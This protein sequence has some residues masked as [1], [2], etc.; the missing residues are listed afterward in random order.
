MAVDTPERERSTS[1]EHLAIR[2]GTLHYRAKVAL[3]HPAT[4]IGLVLIALFGYLIVAPVISLLL[5]GLQVGFGDEAKT[6]AAAGDFTGYYLERVFDSPVSSIIFYGP[7]LNTLLVAGSSILLALAIGVPVA[8]LLSRTDLPGRRWFSGALIIPYMLPAWTFA[9]AWTTI[10]KNRSSAGQL[11]WME[12]IGWEPPNWLAY[13]PLPIVVIFALHFIPF[14]ILLVTNAMKNLPGELDEAAKM[15]GATPWTRWRRI[16]LPLMRPAVL[17][18][19]TLMFAK[20]IGEF[21][22]AY[23]L[24]MPAGFQVL[25]TTLYQSISTQQAGVAGVIAAVM[26]G[27]GAIS[28]M[29]D[30]RFLREARRFTTLSGRSGASRSASL[31]RWRGVAWGA[32]A[33]LFF[34][35]VIVP[36]GTLLLSTLMRIPGNF[37]ASN[38]TLDYWIGH[39][40]PTAGFTSGVLVSAQTWAAAWNTIWMVGLA[41]GITG[42]LGLLVGYVVV[43]CPVPRLG[44]TLRV[45]TFMPYLVPGIAFAVAYLSLFAV[46]R[47]P[48]PALYGTAAILILIMV[49]D[50]MPFASR[51]GVS[52]MMQLGNEPEE[53][54]QSL[55]ARWSRRMRTI[56]IPL[57]RSALASATLLPFISGVQ[58]LSL[59][60]ILATP[61][62]QLLT[63][64]SM[65]LIDFGYTHAANAV[66]VVICA[67]ALL[68]SWA[69]QRLFRSNLAAGLGG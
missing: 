26:V 1:R 52:A 53:A 2:T 64:L 18:A 69:T 66:V 12:A 17:S 30:I 34:V 37:S 28:L 21:G 20:A 38:F 31:G 54:A 4:L 56:V 32:T 59:V 27:L 50:E 16:T 25:S 13:G 14:V 51:A 24:G 23:V 6:G 39:D 5:S 47:G 68:G 60:I 62:T 33:G 58:G 49:A 43:R 22:V 63:T 67:I 41:A 10:F 45:I 42:I 55:G 7:L 9:L 29:V 48:I 11:G 15:L 8:W 44:N 36:L 65:T 61:G 3:R 46:P 35:S 19:A 57:Q 40:L